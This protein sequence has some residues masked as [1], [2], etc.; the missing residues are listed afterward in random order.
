[1]CCTSVCKIVQRFKGVQY[2][3]TNKEDGKGREETLCEDLCRLTVLVV[4]E[5]LCIRQHQGTD[6][7]S[8][9]DVHSECLM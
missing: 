9:S 2:E 8:V 5:P 1:M 3:K 6:G 7:H 4:H